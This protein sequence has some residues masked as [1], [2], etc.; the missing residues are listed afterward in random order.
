MIDRC[1]TKTKGTD[2]G[3]SER[4][5]GISQHMILRNSILSVIRFGEHIFCHPRKG[6]NSVFHRRFNRLLDS[7]LRGNDKRQASGVSG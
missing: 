6:G 1:R 5:L 4:A 2:T 3:L 7:R